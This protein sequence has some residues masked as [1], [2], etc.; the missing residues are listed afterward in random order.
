MS[1]RSW[2]Y[3]CY[4]QF[5]GETTNVYQIIELCCRWLLGIVFLYGSIP[6]VFQMNEFADTV[7]AYG[8]VPDVTVFPV[9]IGIVVLELATG[10]G[11]LLQKR[12]AQHLALILL[13]VFI[14]VL[15]YGIWL[16]LDID[17]G[18]FAGDEN[19]HSEFSSLKMA[20]LRD[21][22]LL[23]PLFFLYCQPLFNKTKLKECNVEKA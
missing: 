6:K 17:C 12:M 14:G 4:H 19:T 8:I 7:G 5:I 23:L 20:L 18:C 10:V 9:A 11:L 2:K 21:L 1:S 13:V 3:Y 22:L 16:G 15:T